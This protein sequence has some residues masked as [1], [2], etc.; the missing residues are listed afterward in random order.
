MQ[1]S[2]NDLKK[3][4]GRLAGLIFGLFLY[5]LGIAFTIEAH[6]GYAPWDVFHQ[7]IS[8]IAGQGIVP[9]S[10]IYSFYGGAII[11]FF[12]VIYTTLKVKEMPPKE[13]AEFHGI[14]EQ[15]AKKEKSDFITLLKNAPK[16]FWTVGLVQFFCWA[17]FMYM[18]TYTNGGIAE[19]V[20]NTTDAKSAG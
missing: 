4:S 18:W 11:L 15:P 1:N 17:A 13:Y 10:V 7:G 19:N 9:D 12:C 20:W 8:N 16:V 2:G 6:F 14:E 5:A 3:F